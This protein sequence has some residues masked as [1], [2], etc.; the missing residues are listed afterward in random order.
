M[1]RPFIEFIQAQA[2]PWR[3]GLYGESRPGTQSRVLS[4]DEATG[5][6]TMMLHYPSG[7]RR[8]VTEHLLVDEE[9]FVLA[10]DLAVDGVAHGRYTYAHH[11][12]GTT[13]HELASRDGAVVLSFFSGEPRAVEGE[14][15]AGLFDERRA[16]PFIDA[17][18]GDWGGNFHPEFPAGAGRKFM[19]RDPLDGEETWILGTMPLRRGRRPEKHPVVEE[20]FQLSGELVGHRGRMLGGAYFWRP[21][22]EWHGPFGS[23]T[24]NLLLF[25]TKGG[26]LSTEYS[27]EEVEFSW[28]PSHD[29]ILPEELA[30]VDRASTETYD[31]LCY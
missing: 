28:D 26:P 10:G 1:S 18:E 13:H 23:P 7:Y 11:P 8:A 20:M 29:P 3:E 30:K 27:E 31:C 4:M 14:A 21:P 22:E 5:A 19:R 24:G 25:R 6:S 2:I 15:P 17:F 16:V 12:A 9:F